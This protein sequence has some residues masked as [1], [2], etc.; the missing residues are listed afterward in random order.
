MVALVEHVERGAVGVHCTYL[1]PDG[2]GKADVEPQKAMFGPVRG[3]AVR[4][5][6]PRAGEWFA[7]AEGIETALSI[8]V[9]CRMPVWAALSTGGMKN[10][11]LPPEVTR[12]VTIADNDPQARDKRTGE[13][14]FH[15]DGRPIFPGQD[16]ARVAATRWLTEGRHVRLALPPEAG[17]D[18]NDVLTGRVAVNEA[19]HVA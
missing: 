14:K 17:T 4:F 8:V 2:S 5:G 12:V 11:I 16:A 3:G 9:A 10:L 19:R 13:L 7:V 1:R 6:M 18:F 15:A